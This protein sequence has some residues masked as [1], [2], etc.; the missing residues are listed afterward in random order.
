M[1]A[2]AAD[3]LRTLQAGTCVLEYR[4]QPCEHRALVD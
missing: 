1:L 3:V 4:D 2:G